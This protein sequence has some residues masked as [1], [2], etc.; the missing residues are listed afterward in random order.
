LPLD[1]GRVR[2]VSQEIFEQV[3]TEGWNGKSFVQTLGGNDLDATSL[4]FPMLQFV[5]PRDHRMTATIEAIKDQLV[6]DSLVHRYKPAGEK[7]D[8]LPGSEGTFTACS[9]WLVENLSRAG[10]LREARFLFEKMLT[11]ANH[12]GL[13]AEE[14]SSTGQSLGNFPQA[15]THLALITAAFDLDENLNQAKRI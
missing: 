3:M 1:I 9:F 12:L 2:K 15:F 5:T 4:L 10:R 11:Y 6:S 13:Y 14:I 7:S 8:G